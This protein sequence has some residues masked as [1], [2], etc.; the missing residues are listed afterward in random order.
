MTEPFDS[1]DEFDDPKLA[2]TP[3]Q[4]KPAV[5]EVHDTSDNKDVPPVPA[6]QPKTAK[7][8]RAKKKVDEPV[9]IPANVP[10]LEE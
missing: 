6:E 9:E 2:V 7:R 8:G 10:A 5:T 3:K 1:F 4:F